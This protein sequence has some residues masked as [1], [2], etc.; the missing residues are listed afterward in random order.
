M[1]DRMRSLIV[2]FLTVTAVLVLLPSVV[3]G[4][5]TD[6]NG[7]G[8]ADILWHYHSSGDL[9]LWL[10][11]GTGVSSAAIDAGPP[12]PFRGGFG[13]VGVGDFNGDGKTDILWRNFSS[14]GPNIGRLDIWFMD[15]AT[16]SRGATIP[17]RPLP[18]EWMIEG[19][20]DFDGDGK[21]D[22]L[23]RHTFGL[24]EIWFM[25]GA[26][27]IRSATFPDVPRCEPSIGDFNGDGKADIFWRF[28]SG[29]FA[30]WLM[31]GPGVSSSTVVPVGPSVDWRISGVGDF[32]GDGR[33][34][35]LWRHESGL[36]H[37]W[38][39]DGLNVIGTASPGSVD[40]DWTIAKVGDFDGDGKADILW[41]HRFDLMH[42]WLMD[43][44][45]VIDTADLSWRSGPHEVNTV[46][47]DWNIVN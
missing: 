14:F 43:G 16:I 4:V 2:A 28:S 29:M 1:P 13:I 40:L 6:F 21:A 11:D 23:W 30:I 17:D 8:K 31:D 18:F 7:D 42:I 41:R 32:D 3:W 35:I 5:N 20:G 34:D 26:T 38:F 22:I 12:D 19:I 47:S 33:A 25:D 24:I 36:V 46:G 9:A 10:M 44:G 39:M 45:G 37:I 27:I 15:G